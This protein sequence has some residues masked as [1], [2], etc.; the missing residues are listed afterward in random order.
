MRAQPIAMVGG[1]YTDDSLPWSC[2]DT[3]N[4]L[5]TRAEVEGTR[6]PWKLETCPGL[7]ESLWLGASSAP[8]R[9][10]HDLEGQLYF[11]SGQTLYRKRVDGGVDALGLIPGVS[12]VQMTHNQFKTGYQLLVENGQGGGGYVYST[13][14]N[15]FAKITDEG[16]PGSI[17]SDYL[18]SY[19]L[20][21]EPLGR[22][23]FH[24]NLADATDYN[25]LDRYEAEAS[26][27]KI[28]GLAVSQFEV[29]V[30][31]Q[32]TVEFFFNSGGQTGTFQNRR[33]SITRGCASRHTI[34]KLDNSLFWLG[35]D[36][37]VYRL[38]GYAARRISTQPLE[39]AIAGYNWSEA[40]S[41][42]WEDRGYKVYY[43]TFPGGLTFGYDVVT[44]LWTRRQSFGMDRWRLSH[45]VK[46]GNTWYGG[47]FQT[48]RIW[49]I[50]WDYYLEGQSPM[51]RRHVTGV[52]HD[53]QSQLIIPNAE[54]IF[55][56]GTLPT[57]PQAPL[58]PAPQYPGA[59]T[60]SGTLANACAGPTYTATL[61][62][63]GGSTPVTIRKSAGP[64]TL[65]ISPTG[66]LSWPSPEVGAFT[67]S[68]Q[69]R[70]AVGRIANF[71]AQFT[72]KP[73]AWDF[74]TFT[75]P[76]AYG[77]TGNQFGS[78]IYSQMF[79]RFI[80]CTS[81]TRR[82][83]LDGGVTWTDKGGP[84]LLY[85][86]QN[87][88]TGR[89]V[90]FGSSGIYYS[91]NGG[92][93]ITTAT[94]GITTSAPAGKWAGGKFL[95][96]ASSRPYSSVDGSVWVEGATYPGL[97]DTRVSFVYADHLQKYVA[98]ARLSGA[99]V[100]SSNGVSGFTTVGTGPI[101]CT[102][103]H[104][105]ANRQLIY[106]NTGNQV[107]HSSDGINFTSVPV[108]VSGSSVA[109][110]IVIPEMGCVIANGE[111]TGAQNS[112]AASFDG[113]NTWQL[114]PGLKRWNALGWSPSLG[115]LAF[116]GAFDVYMAT[117]TCVL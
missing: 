108:F 97:S 109:G 60:L 42:V 33:Q 59:P 96:Y 77:G 34:Q 9:G 57:V 36:G 75:G 95:A 80:A 102:Q 58:G 6:T 79:S 54:L 93:T 51:I 30:F 40:I 94:G 13:V 7:R 67:V 35:D 66:A 116:V 71:Q 63:T 74:T 112:L 2:Q 28:V 62:T 31:G 114:Y 91:D 81:T 46:S 48:G 99:V 115:K 113:G 14:D 70:D 50:E 56:T 52:L 47:D 19:M 10:M 38:D 39:K 88:A 53:N 8:I 84:T 82:V 100:H 12:R 45:I 25:T 110:L 68:A 103:L 107:F 89:I 85:Q 78:C 55:G 98:I 44:G 106:G 86:A 43:L 72:I 111:A 37:I 101:G 104:Y 26:P 3:V 15:T 90:F 117:A 11:V 1:F 61:T 49:V 105:D 23:W 73:L 17:S 20:G 92:D 22:Y 64:V 27:D 65:T 87:P 21:V 41:Y 18:D 76:Y 69:A 5:P 83:S 32:R 29:V 16:Y 24:S 4:W